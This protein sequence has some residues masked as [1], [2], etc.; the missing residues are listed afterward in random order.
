MLSGLGTHKHSPG[1]VDL[2]LLEGC[3]VRENGLYKKAAD[4]ICQSQ[5]GQL[6]WHQM[7]ESF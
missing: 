6:P 4:N 5:E 3:G 1:E 7:W 2:I